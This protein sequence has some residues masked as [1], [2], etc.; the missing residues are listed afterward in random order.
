MPQIVFRS[1]TLAKWKQENSLYIWMSILSV[2]TPPVNS[3][4]F[5]VRVRPQFS[6]YFANWKYMW[7]FCRWQTVCYSIARIKLMIF[8]AFEIKRW[9]NKMGTQD[10]K[11]LMKCNNHGIIACQSIRRQEREERHVTVGFTLNN[12]IAED[13]RQLSL[14]LYEQEQLYNFPQRNSNES[15]K[16]SSWLNVFYINT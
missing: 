15:C 13:L 2:S 6:I 11:V 14:S 10:P 4:Q 7:K 1:S 9:C 12:Y 16:G 5:S 3:S 8:N